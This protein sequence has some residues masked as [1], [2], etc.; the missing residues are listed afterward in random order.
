VAPDAACQAL[1]F[2]PSVTAKPSTDPEALATAFARLEQALEDRTA[3][4]TKIRAELA[5]LEGAASAAARVKAQFLS[6]V[7]HELRTPMNGVLGMAEL[8]NDTA[9]TGEQREYV[10]VLT[11][12]ARSLLRVVDDILDYSE[13]EAGKLALE[14]APF[15]LHRCIGDALRLLAPAAR[16]KGLELVGYVDPELPESVSGD[17]TRL[18]QIVSNLAANAIKFTSS[19]DVTVELHGDAGASHGRL[20][21]H[22]VVRDTGIGILAEQQRT[23]FGAF[24]QGDGSRT[25]RFGGTGLGLT[26]SQRL[27]EMMGGRLWVESTAGQGSAFHFTLPVE[28]AAAQPSLA[29]AYRGPLFG[30][31]ALVVHD[32]AATRDAVGRTL[33]RCGM[34]ATH[35]ATGEALRRL[36][37]RNPRIDVVLMGL[38]GAGADVASVVAGIHEASPAVPVLLMGSAQE[39]ARCGELP[40]HAF[41]PTPVP[42]PSLLAAVTAALAPA[43]AGDAGRRVARRDRFRDVRVLVA[44]DNPINQQV[45]TLMLEGWGARV[46]VAPSGRDAL[47][48]LERHTFD[49]VLMDVQMPDG[50]GFETTLAIRAREA[51][52]RTRVPIVALTAQRE[53]RT[54]C[55]ASGMDDYLTK[56]V[57]PAELADALERVVAARS[58]H[59]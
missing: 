47:A 7:S 41:L 55:L 58:G 53:D 35:A 36:R 11:S 24:E 23:I 8:L 54:R 56:P 17:L 2:D 26:I 6:N 42:A 49:L 29:D 40:I 13:I 16:A 50:D 5:D 44:E 43:P 37:A 27:V 34:P 48:Q 1:E 32:H 12:S 15:H 21:L 4:L 20:Q 28:A 22:G 9:L 10:D 19:G 38:P 3:E 57:V 39:A 25:R 51:G 33:E 52:R 45:I 31:H 59:A 14:R 30:A 18:R 46:T